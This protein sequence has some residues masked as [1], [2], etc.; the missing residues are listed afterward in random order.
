MK[1][2]DRI[3]TYSLP[4]FVSDCDSVLIACQYSAAA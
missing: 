3:G 4:G 1:C 2:V